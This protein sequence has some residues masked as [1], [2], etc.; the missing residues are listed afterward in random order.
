M[1]A[2]G[3]RAVALSSAAGAR[4]SSGSGLTFQHFSPAATV[5]RGYPPHPDVTLAKLKNLAAAKQALLGKT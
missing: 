1:R 2:I 4:A 3:K 5:A